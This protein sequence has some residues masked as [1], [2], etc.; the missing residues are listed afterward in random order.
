MYALG[1]MGWPPGPIEWV[2]IL[3]IVLLI[4][5][6]KQV[7]KL[8]K[9]GKEQVANLRGAV[10]EINETVKPEDGTQAGVVTPE[11]PVAAPAPAPVTQAPV[12]PAPAPAPTPEVPVAAPAPAPAPVAAPEQAPPAQ[13]PQQQ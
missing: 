5:G 1:V 7:P 8:I 11:V 4:F 6:P 12:A 3:A 13:A 10:D 9:M 2:I